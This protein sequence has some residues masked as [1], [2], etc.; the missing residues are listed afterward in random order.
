[1]QKTI[2]IYGASGGLGR[3]IAEESLCRGYHVLLAGRT[4]S[5]L[6]SLKEKLSGDAHIR[7]FEMNSSMNKELFSE[8]DYVINAV[9]LDTRKKLSHQS[10]KEIQEQ[11]NINLTGPVLMT[12]AALQAFED[13]G[14]GA[15]LHIGGFGKAE[16]YSPY[17]TVD[18][19]SRSG[20]YGFVKV[21]NCEI[22]NPQIQVKYFCPTPADTEAEL[23]YHPL[24][25]S[26]GV[27]ISTRKKVAVELLDLMV[28]KSPIKVMGNGLTAL[29]SWF[30]R[31]FSSLSE[32]IIIEYIRKKT[33][34]FFRNK[35]EKK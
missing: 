31:V 2:M 27:P 24:W 6:E 29:Y 8:V 26:M 9:G 11:V 22:E 12:K 20:L 23:P 33:I 18:F 19:S 32:K 1:M 3:A 34:E 4:R 25:K 10:I 17:Y 21:I 14:S 16:W 15:I 30:N 13:K 35:E 5:K 28:S 7:V